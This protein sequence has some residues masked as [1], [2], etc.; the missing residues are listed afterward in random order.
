MLT[1][2]DRTPRNPS[3][4]GTSQ[5]PSIKEGTPTSRTT[6]TAKSSL[7]PL[8][9][10]DE[11]SATAWG[12][13]SVKPIPRE[14]PSTEDFSHPACSAP[15]DMEEALARMNAM[16]EEQDAQYDALSTAKKAPA[17]PLRTPTPLDSI[18]E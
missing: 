9:K 16:R 6:S 3:L 13:R 11:I 4:N 5:F 2:L 7:L 1:S 14:S 10:Q 8:A 12:A 18:P 15:F 17:S